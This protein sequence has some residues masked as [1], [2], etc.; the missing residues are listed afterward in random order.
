VTSSVWWQNF[1]FQGERIV[2]CQSGKAIEIQRDGDGQNVYIQHK[3]R[4]GNTQKFLIKYVDNTKVDRRYSK[5]ELN[6]E[7]GLKVGIPFSIYT[8]MRCE[9]AIDIKDDKLVVKRKNGDKS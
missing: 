5:G 8:R 1:K 7:Y 4:G 3:P 6:K 9:F 2:N